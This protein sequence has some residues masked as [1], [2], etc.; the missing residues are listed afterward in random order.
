LKRHCFPWLKLKT[1]Q[2]HVKT[3]AFC[4]SKLQKNFAAAKRLQHSDPLL[5]AIPQHRGVQ[6]LRSVSVGLQ[7]QN[8]EALGYPA[9]LCQNSY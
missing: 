3:H 9:W 5:Q 4:W 2:N 7:R 1:I 6:Q 8:V